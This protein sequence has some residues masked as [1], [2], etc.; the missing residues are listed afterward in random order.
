[1]TLCIGLD[2]G[3]I[4]VSVKYPDIIAAEA[5]IRQLEAGDYF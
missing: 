1:M 3:P 2:V 5:D 4:Y